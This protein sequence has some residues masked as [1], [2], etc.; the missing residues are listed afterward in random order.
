MIAAAGLALANALVLATAGV[1]W[2]ATVV[3]LA[4][5]ALAIAGWVRMRADPAPGETWRLLGAGGAFGRPTER[6]VAVAGV[7]QAASTPAVTPTAQAMTT[8]MA[9][10]PSEMRPP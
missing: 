9:P 7:A 2:T 3:H 8:E 1:G 10:T 5:A 6:E 4:T